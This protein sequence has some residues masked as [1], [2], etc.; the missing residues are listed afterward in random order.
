MLICYFHYKKKLS[1]K[2]CQTIEYKVN[3]LSSNSKK[4][5]SIVQ[6]VFLD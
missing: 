3:S 5:E 4:Y 1:L 2:K 6:K